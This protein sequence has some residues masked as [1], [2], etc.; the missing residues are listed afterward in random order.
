MGTKGSSG[1]QLRL[2][3]ILNYIN[4]GL[5]NLIPIFYTPIMLRLLGQSEYGLYKLSAT[6]TSYLSLVAF[7]IGSAITRYIIK[8]GTEEGK[9]AEEKMFGLFLTI[10]RVI[11]LV[12]LLG[13]VFLIFNVDSWYSASL[14]SGQLDRM[15][16]LMAIMTLNTALSFVLSPYI[17]VVTAHERY[18]FVQC[19]HIFAT[20][21]IPIANL[22]V[23][24][25]GFAS[26]GMAVSSLVLQ[27]L[28]RIVYLV[29]VKRNLHL[30][31]RFEKVSFS[32]VKEVLLFSFWVF[33][34]E[35]VDKLYTATDT[36]LIGAVPNLATNG[37]AVY[38]VG[39]VFSGAVLTIAVGLSGLLSPRTNKLVFEGAS[40]SELT[41]F[42]IRIARM[43]AIIVG[44]IT[45]GF[46]VFGT[47]FI[48]F[49][50][51]DLYRDSYWVALLI[52]IPNSVPI[53]QNV[54][55]NI[56]VAKNKHRF[57]SL[58]Y[59]G[60]AIVNV[61]GT[62]F[63]LK[64][65]G[66]IGAALMTGIARIIGQGFVMNWYYLKRMGLE[67]GRFWKSILPIYTFAALLAFSAYIV[68]SFLVDFYK[69]GNLIFCILI[70]TLSYAIFC[71]LTIMN[72]QERS[73]IKDVL[74][75]K[76]KHISAI[77]SN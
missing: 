77:N 15:R 67:I 11:G 17:S 5:G 68:G 14:D 42:A 16:I 26:I 64:Y 65:M 58:V 73:L 49:Y 12:A 50:V 7:G 9:E 45:S 60:I 30:R 57:R 61:I 63:L 43:Q 3:V 6:V 31:P 21:V 35:I 4:I 10:F 23:L 52:M 40:N 48:H 72:N 33:V 1:G 55:L 46:I 54:F 8:T 27:F 74:G 28:M 2:G 71:W 18:V 53:V 62:W 37:V 70:F 41:D 19:M 59:L 29:Y 51:G 56:I 44:L 13:G 36:T 24:F 34:G 66:V 69:V 39:T 25:M 38:H 75:I 22:I 20:C 47:P 76:T 32:K